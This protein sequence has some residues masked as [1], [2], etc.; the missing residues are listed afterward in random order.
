MKLSALLLIQLPLWC[1][2]ASTPRPVLCP[3]P[4]PPDPAMM[5]PTDLPAPD[6]PGFDPGP[7]LAPIG[8]E[9]DARVTYLQTY[10]RDVCQAP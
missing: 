6:R 10:I 9:A 2:C 8:L 4:P 3:K 1:A 7:K 5:V